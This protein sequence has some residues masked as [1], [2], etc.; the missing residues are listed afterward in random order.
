MK[1]KVKE[2]W[3]KDLLSDKFKQGTGSLVYKDDITDEKTHCC[4]GVL[5][6]TRKRISHKKVWNEIISDQKGFLNEKMIDWSG[7]P[8]EVQS[9]LADFNDAGKS[10]K[11][12]AAYIKRYL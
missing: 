11:W 6:E 1:P 5:C 7:L 2:E 3:I 10:F 9:K 12:I 4:L 8:E